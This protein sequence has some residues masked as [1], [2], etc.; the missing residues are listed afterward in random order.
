MRLHVPPR[1]LCTDNAAMIAAAG[2]ARLPAGERAPLTM[3]AVPDL[4][5]A[6]AVMNFE[7]VL[8]GLPDA[9]IARRRRSCASCSGTRR[10]RCSPGARRA[11]RAGRLLKEVFAAEASLVRRLAE[12]LA[13]GESRSERATRSSRAP[14]GARCPSAS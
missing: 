5:L 10:P 6:L 11:A 1:R 12:T 4:A 14:I 9:V 7:A 8:P 13:T 3:N 2:T